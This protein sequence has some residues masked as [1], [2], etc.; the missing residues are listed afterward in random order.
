MFHQGNINIFTGGTIISVTALANYLEKNNQP[1]T[2]KQSLIF[3]TTSNY[4]QC[5]SNNLLHYYV[6]AVFQVMSLLSWRLP[7]VLM[8]THLL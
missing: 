8:A 1:T 4:H 6:I 2:C 3:K 5:K 7:V